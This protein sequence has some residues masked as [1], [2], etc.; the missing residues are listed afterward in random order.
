MRMSATHGARAPAEISGRVFLKL[1]LLSVIIQHSY[2]A[3]FDIKRW[4]RQSCSSRQFQC[5]SGQCVDQFVICDGEKNCDDGSDETSRACQNIG[6]PSYAYRCAYGACVNS[7]A[8]CNNKQEC[9]DG[10]D[11]AGCGGSTSN[12]KVVCK[13]NQFLC[14]SGTCVDVFL[15][16]DGTKDCDDGSDETQEECGTFQCPSYAFRC[17]YGA[18]IDRTGLCN[19]VPQCADGSD[20]KPERCGPKPTP[21]PTPAPTPPPTGG[22]KLPPQPENG[23]YKLGGCSPPCQPVPG[24]TV[25][26]A[27]LTYSCNSGFVLTG[28]PVLLCEGKWSAEFPTCARA[29]CSA[30]INPSREIECKRN[31]KKVDCDQP[32]PPGTKAMVKC[33][34]FYTNVK[35][36]SDFDLTCQSD[37]KWSRQVSSCIPKCGEPNPDGVPF[38]AGGTEAKYGEFPWHA[39]IYRML[40][41]SYRQVCGAAHCFWN[42]NVGGPFDYKEFRVAVGKFYRKWNDKDGKQEKHVQLPDIHEVILHDRFRGDTLNWANDIAV[43]NVKETIVMS[44]AVRPI[45]VDF[46]KE[47]ERLFLPG[48]LGIVMGWGITEN[49]TQ[50]ETIHKATLP[51]V[52]FEVCEKEVPAS[53]LAFLTNNKFCA[54]YRNGTSVCPGDSGGGYATQFRDGKWYLM[55]LKLVSAFNSFKTWHW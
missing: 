26:T 9:A 24:Q 23:Q 2:G 4:K 51:Y 6:C 54:G 5:N 11:E 12:S 35:E 43:V 25:D 47:Y 30:L 34:T 21:K 8:R 31:E 19:G 53:F 40:E 49:Q 52:E 41:G 20:E 14:K 7:G 13:N 48:K 32:M 17:D 39:G 45:C 38:V 36:F 55:G 27:F 10:S 1:L 37:G 46:N 16:C 15:L 33:G 3:N 44:I 18:C 29:R 50:S 28:A 42:S 22:C